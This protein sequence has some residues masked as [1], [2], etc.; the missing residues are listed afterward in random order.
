M[1]AAVFK[2]GRYK[3]C[4]ALSSYS[5]ERAR[6]RGG[7]SSCARGAI[8]GLCRVRTAGH[9]IASARAVRSEPENFST[10][11]ALFSI[12][13]ARLAAMD[14]VMDDAL[15]PAA[16]PGPRGLGPAAALPPAQPR[17]RRADRSQVLLR[18]CSLEE[19]LAPD[20]PAR[21]VWALACRWDLSLFL[22]AIAARGEASGRAAT[23]PR[24]LICLWLYA[25]TQGVSNGRELDRLCESHDAY[26]WICGGVGLNYH[27][28]NDFRVDHAQALDGLLTQMI[29][30]LLR[31]K[32]VAVERISSDGTRQRCG[33]GRNSFKTA[34]TLAG[35]L[36]DAREHVEALKRQARDPAAS[37]R[38]QKAIERGA[39][40]RVERLE[41]AVEE[42]KKVEEAKARQK[43]KPSKHQPAKASGTDPQARQ[44]R[45][46]GGGTAPAYNV[47]FAVATEGRAIVGVEVTNAGSD[48]HESQP[49]RQQVERRTGKKVREHLVDGGYVGLDSIEQSAK[50]GTTIYA[51]V[52]KPK[53]KDADPHQPKKTDA[54][55]VADWRQRMGTEQAKAIYKERAST[56]ET[57]NGECKSYRGLGQF[58]VRGIDKVKCVA[59]WAALAYNVVHFARH[60]I[61]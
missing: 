19:L 23:D 35:H 31:S 49:M 21:I 13:R 14:N 54:Q 30:A 2:L 47:Q 12:N 22:A 18:P 55:E 48:V 41:Q 5:G 17:L 39:R 16:S 33:A 60:L 7:T 38:R 40:E 3:K 58:L 44:M 11:R 6:V 46:P 36:K 29:G 53:K 28:I 43:E 1:G 8:H 57:V 59:L 4:R 37:A 27:T 24:I 51:L 9:S 34:Q 20:H 42:V 52:P 45:M 56:V 10:G 32:L 25:Y 26:R 50:A 61:A 15:F